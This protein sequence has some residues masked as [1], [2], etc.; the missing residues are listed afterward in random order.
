MR[1]SQAANQTSFLLVHTTLDRH[2]A[3]PAFWRESVMTTLATAPVLFV[4]HGAPTFALEP[5]Q[6]GPQLHALGATLKG[7]TAVLVISPHW[8]SR[9]VRVMSTAQPET[10]HD[11]GGFPEALYLLR[12]QPATRGRLRGE[13]R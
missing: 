9:D 6:L 11:F 12:Y 10:M 7:I 5:G 3:G 2:H 13:P 8:Q 4:S 1:P